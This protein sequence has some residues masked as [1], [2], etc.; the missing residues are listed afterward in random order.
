VEKRICKKINLANIM[1][2][3]IDQLI[4]IAKKYKDFEVKIK[5]D[6]SP[7]TQL[8]LEFSNF[9]E[10]VQQSYFPETVFYSE[11]KYQALSFPSFVVDPLDG[12]REFIMGSHEWSISV[13]YIF[14]QN[15]SGEGWIGNLNTKEYFFEPKT[16]RDSSKNKLIGEVSRAEFEAGLYAQKQTPGIKLIPLGSIAYKLGRLAYGKSDF[17]VSLKPKNIWDIAAGTILCQKAGLN[18]YSQGKRVFKVQE[19]YGPPL[20]WC[21]ERNSSELLKIFS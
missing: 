6:F 13:A 7:V 9:L 15:F 16:D 2:D 14:N 11:E 8:D 12:T 19:A 18:F 21:D 4:Q 10:G 17:V 1:N 3:K 20:I 5:S